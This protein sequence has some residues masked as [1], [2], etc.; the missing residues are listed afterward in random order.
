MQKF[1][2]S[3]SALLVL[4]CFSMATQALTLSAVQSRKMH[5]GSPRDIPIDFSRSVSGA[6]TV[7]PREIGAGHEIVFQFDE[8]IAS[9]GGG[10]SEG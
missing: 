3:I 8:A 9:L 6:V 7:D 4:A 2:R 1:I 10:R 5:A